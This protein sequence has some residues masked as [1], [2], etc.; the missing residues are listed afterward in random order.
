[1]SPLGHEELAGGLKGSEFGSVRIILKI[2][3]VKRP[4]ALNFRAN[5]TIPQF[6]LLGSERR[7]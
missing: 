3:L 6:S 5:C 2:K 1:M 4:E 7:V